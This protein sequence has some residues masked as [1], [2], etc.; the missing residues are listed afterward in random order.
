[1]EF[2]G[3]HKRSTGAS[4]QSKTMRRRRRRTTSRRSVQSFWN[5]QNLGVEDGGVEKESL[6][7]T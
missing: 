7:V 5:L 1:M 4:E 3:I 2:L 6:S